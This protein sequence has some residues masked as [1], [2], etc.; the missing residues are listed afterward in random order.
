MPARYLRCASLRRRRWRAATDLK[1]RKE[2]SNAA[3][4]SGS[5]A[6]SL[7]KGSV[8]ALVHLS[9]SI[10]ATG[11]AVAKPRTTHKRWE[12]QPPCRG[13]GRAGNAASRHMP[14]AQ[15]LTNEPLLTLVD[16]LREGAGQAGVG[17]GGDDPIG[18]DHQPNVARQ[19][20]APSA[21]PSFDKQQV[22]ATRSPKPMSSRPGAES[23]R[24]MTMRGTIPGGS[25]PSASC[26]HGMW[27]RKRPSH[28]LSFSTPPFSRRQ[29][30]DKLT[31][32]LVCDESPEALGPASKPPGSLPPRAKA[33]QRREY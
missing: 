11:C 20:M 25:A 30:V 27:V 22:S 15:P 33:R 17:H 2:A 32:R 7:I 10:A 23:R 24:P 14:N 16:V 29:N 4:A 26:L 21:S 18:S 5:A 31:G 19:S 1:R 3:P 28:F 12:R 8:D 9:S 6:H 13:E